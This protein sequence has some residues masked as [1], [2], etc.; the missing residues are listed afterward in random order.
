MT[1]YLNSSIDLNDSDIVSA[2]DELPLWSAMFGLL[3]LKYVPLKKGLNVLDVGC[4][5]GF[6]LLELAQ[7]LGPTCKVYGIDPW[8]PALARAEQKARLWN[9]QNVELNLGDAA[10]MPFSDRQFDLIV[11][12]LGVNNFNDPEAVLRECWRVAKPAAKIVLTTNLQGHMQE[13][14]DVFETTLLELG[15]QTAIDALNL[16]I[17]KRATIEKMVTLFGKG[18]FGVKKVHQESTWMRFTDGSALLRHYFIKLGFLDAWKDVIESTEQ[19][20]VF[21]RLEGNLN[22]VAK[23]EGELRLTIPMAYIEGEKI[24]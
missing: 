23:E 7:R 21:A 12:N 6:P 15:R 3:L 16:H 10:A 20:E 18:G 11:S 17:E 1:D 4:G 13:F 22:H 2:Y 19:E 24:S 14:Y 9:V 8:Q 5:T